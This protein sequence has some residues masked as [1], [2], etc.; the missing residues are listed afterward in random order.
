MLQH[1]IEIH[2]TWDG[3]YLTV[4]AQL[5]DVEDSITVVSWLLLKVF[6]WQRFTQS[7]FLSLGNSCRALVASLAVGLEGLVSLTRADPTATDFHLHGFSHLSSQCRVLA[8]VCALASYPAD[9]GMQDVLSDDRLASQVDAFWNGML[10][11]LRWLQ[12]LPSEFW[13]MLVSSVGLAAEAATIRSTCLTASVTSLGYVHASLMMVLHSEPWC[14]CT[15]SVDQ[16]L[17]TLQSEASRLSHPCSKQLSD[18]LLM[19]GSRQTVVA[20][21]A[22][23]RAC[24]F[25]TMGVEQQH[26]SYA[27]MKR[28][29][30]DY[31]LLTLAARGYL[32]SCRALFNPEESLAA[33]EK[34]QREQQK[35]EKRQ[36]HKVGGRSMFLQHM[37][38]KDELPL[39]E[40]EDLP[41]SGQRPQVLEQQ[42]RLRIAQQLWEAMPAAKRAG[43]DRQAVKYAQVQKAH[44]AEQQ[45]QLNSRRELLQLRKQHEDTQTRTRNVLSS[46]RFTT[47]ELNTFSQEF[48]KQQSQHQRFR[49]R[50][51]LLMEAPQEPSESEMRRLREHW[52][53][54]QR[55]ETRRPPSWLKVIAAQR[56]FFTHS[57]VTQ[58]AEL[59]SKA[60]FLLYIKQSPIEAVALEMEVAFPL[61]LRGK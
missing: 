23:M 50:V 12:E 11:E 17:E 31:G 47:Q 45:E 29:H 52:P 43:F 42:H 25:S 53:E 18:Y 28:L 15:G 7:R 37:L 40:A 58:S 9:S 46:C 10:D 55:E 1:F 61:Q 51:D 41:P 35:L 54:A 44:I 6:R 60:W 27:T 16:S 21:L 3:H 48:Q 30:P 8:V 36:P 59:N 32:H 49:R 22:L 38:T 33:M 14:W 57:V 34:L 56:D 4:G 13:C 2:P 5:H 20:I 24:S 39:S 19:G 26:G